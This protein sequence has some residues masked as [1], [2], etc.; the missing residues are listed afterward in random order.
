MDN[1]LAQPLSKNLYA[2]SLGKYDPNACPSEGS[3]HLTGY[4]RPLIIASVIDKSDRVDADFIARGVAS[5]LSSFGLS[6]VDYN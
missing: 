6:S 1:S 4:Q 2:T 5:Q 3:S